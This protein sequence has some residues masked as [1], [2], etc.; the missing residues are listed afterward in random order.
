MAILVPYASPARRREHHSSWLKDHR[1]KVFEIL[2]NVCTKCGFSD[3]RALQIDHINGGGTRW[4]NAHKHNSSYYTEVDVIKNNGQG[5]QLL[6]ANCNWIKREER[7]EHGGR[8]VT[9]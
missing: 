4:R 8:T 9:K 6:C 3:V 7:K 2:G 5:Y 1:K